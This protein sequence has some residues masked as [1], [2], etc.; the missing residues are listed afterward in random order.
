[1]QECIPDMIPQEMCCFGWQESL[2]KLARLLEP[3]INQ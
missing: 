2:R 1:V 3:E